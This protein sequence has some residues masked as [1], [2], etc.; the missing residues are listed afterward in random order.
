MMKNFKHTAGFTMMELVVTLALM[1]VL[2]SFA[3]PAYNGVSE[4]MQ[5]KR[6]EAN[7]Q[8]IREAFF[9][10]FYRMHQQKGRVA[11]FPPEPSNERKLMDDDWASTPMDSLLSPQAP[12]HLF[13]TG[14]LPKNANNTPFMYTTWNDTVDASG[15]VMYYIKIEDVDEDS[16]SYGKSFT[17]SI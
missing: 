15:E 10:Y 14:V 11:H 8:T 9:H 13:A 7:M 4:E 1:G 5:G 17:Y 12:K 6:N 3:I 16:P 2:I